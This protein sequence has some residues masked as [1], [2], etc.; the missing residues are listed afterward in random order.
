MQCVYQETTWF[1]REILQPPIAVSSLSSRLAH[2]PAPAV[3]PYGHSAAYMRET[4]F[5]APSFRR[6]P[7]SQRRD[8]ALWPPM[9]SSPPSRVSYLPQR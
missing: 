8:E 4:D 1:Y 2:L 6:T 9:P 7:I 5:H 3:S